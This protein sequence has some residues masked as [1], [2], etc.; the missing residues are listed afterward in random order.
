MGRICGN[1]PQCRQLSHGQVY[2]VPESF[3][4]GSRFGHQLVYGIVSR[5]CAALV[6]LGDRTVLLIIVQRLVQRFQQ[7]NRFG[8]AAAVE[9]NGTGGIHCPDG[10]GLSRL[11]RSAC[12][13]HQRQQH[14]KKFFPVHHKNIFLFRGKCDIIRATPH[15]ARLT[16][17][18]VICLQI[19]HKLCAVLPKS[20]HFRTEL[21]RFL[22]KCLPF[23]IIQAVY[24]VNGK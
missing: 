5:N 20:R 3:L 24:F 23:I 6:Q 19:T 12:R 8:N 2:T 16:A 14:R 17:L 18:H 15:K 1:A 22:Q 11:C 10:F 7:R 4:Q 9:R 13:Q 21:V